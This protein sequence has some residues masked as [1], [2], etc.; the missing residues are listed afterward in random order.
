MQTRND[1]SDKEPFLRRWHSNGAWNLNRQNS[2]RPFKL[3]FATPATCKMY[4]HNGF[5]ASRQERNIWHTRLDH[6]TA[7]HTMLQQTAH[8]IF[9]HTGETSLLDGAHGGILLRKPSLLFRKYFF[10][11]NSRKFDK[12]VEWSKHTNGASNNVFST[13]NDLLLFRA[14][15][16]RSSFSIKLFKGAEKKM[17]LQP[18]Y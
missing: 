17:L 5:L 2:F 18:K 10:F 1:Q 11:W 8:E 14:R 6:K 7:W 15:D 12:R 13:T 9:L 3:C 4:P 16:S